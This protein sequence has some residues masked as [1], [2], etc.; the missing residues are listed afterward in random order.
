MAKSNPLFVDSTKLQG[1]SI[2]SQF[3]LKKV[4]IYEDESLAVIITNHQGNSQRVLMKMTDSGDFEA[5]ALLNHQKTITY[6]F[7]IER[8]G[9]RILQSAPKQIRAQY[10]IIEEWE[11]LRSRGRV[12]AG[13][14]DPEEFPMTS[15][16]VAAAASV[17]HQPAT[18]QSSAADWPAESARNVKSLIEKWGL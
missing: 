3:E 10:A 7:V 15:P 12:L 4:L 14:V 6:Q 8:A 1:D 16:T 11:P 5:R 18:H 2:G 17:I 13:N 9:R